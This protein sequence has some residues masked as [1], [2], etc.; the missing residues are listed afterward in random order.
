M[1]DK[2]INRTHIF[3]IGLLFYIIRNFLVYTAYPVP[4]IVLR[5]L[6]L[7]VELCWIT[8]IVMRMRFNWHTIVEIGLIAWGYYNLSVT[9][10]WNFVAILLHVICIK[11]R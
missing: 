7:V 4:G 11:K 5:F 1:N 9:G 6:W 2:I 3:F 10:S 8:A